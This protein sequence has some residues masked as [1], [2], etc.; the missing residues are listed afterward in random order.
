MARLWRLDDLAARAQEAPATFVPPPV[1]VRRDLQVGWHAKLLA[2]PEDA[3]RHRFA[4]WLWVRVAQRRNGAAEHA[5]SYT[6]V[7]ESSPQ[8]T[9]GLER[10]EVIVFAPDHVA[11]Y[12]DVA[13]GT[14][15]AKP[16]R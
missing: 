3:R 12:V 5:T 9:P 11:D 1:E 4:E 8:R 7:L 15:R 6:G 16:W 14:R 2:V 13:S 10:G